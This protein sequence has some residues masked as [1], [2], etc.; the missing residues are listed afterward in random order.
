MRITQVISDTNIGGGGKA[1]LNYLAHCDREQFEPSVVLPSG[2]QL[3]PLIEKLEVPLLEISAMA[4]QSFDKKAFA[5]LK[6]ALKELKPDVVHTH[7]SLV[8]RMVAT[9]LGKKVLYT[10]H[11]AFAPTGFKASGVGKTLVSALDKSLASGVIAV[12]HSA[13]ENLVASGISPKRIHVLYN[14]VSALNPISKEE[15]ENLRSGYGFSESDFVVGILA[16]VEVYK[17]HDTLLE[18]IEILVKKGVP[19]KLLVAGDGSYLEEFQKKTKAL[20]EKTV[21][22]TGFVSEVEQVLGAMDVQ[23]NASF[24]SETSC[25][26]LLEGMSLGLPAIA[27]DCGG[28]P[29]LIAHGE[30]GLIFPKQDGNALADAI[31]R[32]KEDKKFYSVLEQGSK[33]RFLAEFTGEQYARNMEEVYQSLA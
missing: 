11:C 29:Y 32:L 14:G 1:L 13:Q 15:R 4:D 27:S 33:S 26:S 10:K 12:G 23:V 7:G 24:E 6:K 17:G 30:N 8:G 25:L 19:V 16:R 20:P 2:S 31:L 21:H 5:P 28:N 9:S 3:T 18:A 22:F